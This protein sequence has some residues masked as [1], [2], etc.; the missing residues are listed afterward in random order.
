MEKELSYIKDCDINLDGNDLLGTSYYADTIEEIV[1]NSDTPFTIGLFGGWGSGKSSIVRTIEEKL[2]KNKDSNAEVFIYDAWKYSKDS[3]RRTFILKLK[4]RFKLDSTAE[5]DSFYKD[6]NEEIKGKTGLVDRW[7]VY[8]LIFVAPLSINFIQPIQGKEFELTTLAITIF[9]TA[10]TFFISKTLIQYKISITKPR[11]FA[12]EEFENIFSEAIDSILNKKRN[13]WVYIKNFLGISRKIDKIIIVIDNIDR[14]HQDLVFELLLTI[15]NFLEKQGVI[16]IVPIDEYETKKHLKELGY[17]AEEFLRKLFNT[18][19]SIK[20]FSENDLYDFAKSLSSKHNLTLSDEVISLVAQAFS[21]NPRG[22]I[23]FLN[24]LQTEILLS[25]KQEDCNNIPKGIISDNLEFLTKILLIREEWFNLYKKFR[26]KPYLFDDINKYLKERKAIDFIKLSDDQLRFL[27]RTRH[28]D[29][30]N[31][32]AFFVNKDVFSD[33]SDEFNNL[34]V[35]QDWSGIKSGI[36]KEQ[37]KF[38]RIMKFIDDKFN[39]DVIGRGLIET[40]GFNVFSLIFKISNDKDFADEF[41]KIYYTKSKNFGN[42]K[43]RLNCL[44]I[45]KIINKFNPKDLV[46]FIK[47]DLIKNQSLNDV[48]VANLQQADMSKKDNYDLLKEFVISFEKNQNNLTAIGTKFSSTI[49]ENPNYFND[50]KTILKKKEVAVKLIKPKLFEEL[51]DSLNADVNSDNTK[52]KVEILKS[53]ENYTIFSVATVEKF[54]DKIITLLSKDDDISYVGFWLN[55]LKGLIV[56]TSKKELDDRVL[57]VLESRYSLFVNNYQSN[58]NEGYYAESLKIFLDISKE[59]YLHGKAEDRLKVRDWLENFFNRDDEQKNYLYVNNIYKEFVKFFTVSDWAYSTRII[60]KFNELSDWGEKQA[61]AETINFMIGKT[62]AEK[63][64]DNDQVKEIFINYLSALKEDPNREGVIIDW[65]KQNIKN[66]VVKERI[67]EKINQYDF[68]EKLSI[69]KVIK[70]VDINLLNSSVSEIISKAN[71][72][73]LPGIIETFN[74]CKVSQTEIKRAIKE[75][76]PTITKE[77]DENRFKSFLEFL[78]GTNLLDKDIT[79][80]VIS[81][82]RPLLSGTSDE[83]IFSL[84]IIKKLRNI[85]TKKKEMI[86][87]IIDGLDSKDLDENGLQ[88]LLDVKTTL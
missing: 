15:K 24:V 61:I 54:I 77:A 82:I 25:K 56:K 53:F 79:D 62:S 69:L 11:T 7:W 28:I 44:E 60:K 48:L 63:G 18:T 30:K 10:L 83:I 20:K 78:S 27:E 45:G 17:N 21:K 67:V 5:F 39:Q 76:L 36:E 57:S 32:E 4:E 9:I 34:V 68:N 72:V 6:A 85:D 1:Q 50:F 59:L 40:T 13:T 73:D 33:I 38:D 37:V 88:L 65:I 55:A 47:T 29:T 31:L 14:C 23:Q 86:K 75:I 26:D 43:S 12:P 74:I 19:L 8:I 22:I 84:S 70:E 58:Y 66:V 52:I 42:I 80:I 46:S 87:T 81:K 3:F 49:N 64:L 41:K 16:F 51:I 2:K 35:S 71:S